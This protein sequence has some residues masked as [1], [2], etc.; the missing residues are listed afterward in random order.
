MLESKEVHAII[1]DENDNTPVFKNTPLTVNLVESPATHVGDV[2]GTIV[3]E[4]NDDPK[5]TSLGYEFIVE[6]QRKGITMEVYKRDG[7]QVPEYFGDVKKLPVK[8]NY[9]TGEIT[10][11]NGFLDIC[12]KET[13]NELCFIYS[14]CFMVDLRCV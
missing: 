7:T 11:R 4:D 8:L 5:Y 6:S 9:A 2:L 1:T 13:K 3:A 14:A 12:R 10:L